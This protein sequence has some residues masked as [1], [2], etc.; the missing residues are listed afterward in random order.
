[1]FRDSGRLDVQVVYL[2]IEVAGALVGEVD[3][4][5]MGPPR[6][7]A[8]EVG[9]ELY[10]EATRGK[11]LGG[12]AFAVFVSYL[13]ESESAGLLEASTAPGNAAMRRILD[14]L[15]FAFVCESMSRVEY[16]LTQREWQEQ[17]GD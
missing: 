5:R 16:V 17:T 6:S 15:G 1:M 7:D 11:G 12:E 9:I 4:R 3:A 13:F 14:K 8:F 2:A 10:D